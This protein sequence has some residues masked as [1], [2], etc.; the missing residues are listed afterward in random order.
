MFRSTAALRTASQVVARRAASTISADAAAAAPAA[1]AAQPQVSRAVLADI[2]ARWSAMAQPERTA[3]VDSLLAAQR[4]D[5]KAL[6]AEQKKA[7]FYIAYGPHGPRE[8]LPK[9][10]QMRVFLATMGVVGIS[11]ALFYWIRLKGGKGVPTT[12]KEW[13]EAANEYARQQGGNPYTGVASD[14]YKG[15]GHVA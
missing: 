2:P 14:N 15:K 8:R 7:L 13:Q 6:S 9:G 11:S 3:V 1:A 10:F 5:W 12:T 4:G